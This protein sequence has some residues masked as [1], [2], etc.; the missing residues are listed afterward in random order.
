MS[1]FAEQEVRFPRFRGTG[2]LALPVLRDGYKEFAIAVE[3]RPE[4][5]N[6]LIV[7][8]SEFSDARKDFFSVTLVNGY[9]E[10]R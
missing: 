1:L 9:I 3:F 10:F 6:G 8:S 4:A 2:Y 7:F 5:K